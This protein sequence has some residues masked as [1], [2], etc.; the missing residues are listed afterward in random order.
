MAKQSD[1]PLIWLHGQVKTPPFSAEARLEAGY[2]L[3][4]LQ[5]GG[6]ISLP[7]ARPMPSIGRHV[8]ELRIQDKT[9]T[10]R[11]IYRI[12][13]DAILILESFQ[14]KT[15]QTPKFVIDICKRRARNYDNTVSKEK[16]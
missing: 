3:R 11:I 6:R 4:L 1:K 2:L 14:K 5:K 15:Q 8:Y 10:H 16:T 13:L 12:D 9:V 7:D